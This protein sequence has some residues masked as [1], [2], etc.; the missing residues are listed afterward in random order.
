MVRSCNGH[1]T[2]EIEATNQ[3]S[4]DDPMELSIG[5]RGLT[6]WTAS[7]ALSL[8]RSLSLARAPR[9]ICPAPHPCPAPLLPPFPHLRHSHLRQALRA[10]TAGM[11]E[12][13][14]LDVDAIDGADFVDEDGT[15]ENESPSGERH[16]SGR[17]SKR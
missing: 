17:A 6:A 14:E 11:R 12:M 7:L 15:G 13:L 16:H 3:A 10:E 9:A 5:I 4:S 2:V 8:S 1:V